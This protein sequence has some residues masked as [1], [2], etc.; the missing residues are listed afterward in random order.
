MRLP[1]YIGLELAVAA[2]T[3]A[4]AVAFA[5]AASSEQP[6]AIFQQVEQQAGML[7]E[8]MFLGDGHCLACHGSDLYVTRRQPARP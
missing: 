5:Q 6:A 1:K 4:A 3:V 2:L 8:K 7:G